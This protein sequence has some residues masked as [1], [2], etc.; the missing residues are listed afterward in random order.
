M[1]LDDLGELGLGLVSLDFE[2]LY[3]PKTFAVLSDL[4]ELGGEMAV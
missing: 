4:G 1:P 3:N 2:C